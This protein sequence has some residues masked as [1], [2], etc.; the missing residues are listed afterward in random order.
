MIS[1]DHNTDTR[2]FVF[3]SEGQQDKQY[4]RLHIINIVNKDFFV[5]EIK[6]TVDCLEHFVHF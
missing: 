5:S 1:L 4:W 6:S 3:T 2:H